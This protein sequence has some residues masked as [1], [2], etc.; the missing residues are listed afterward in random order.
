M[1]Q[2]NM[3]SGVAS[4]IQGSVLHSMPYEDIQRIQG[5]VWLVEK[6]I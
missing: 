3:T 2:E 5:I 1:E 4:G 6:D